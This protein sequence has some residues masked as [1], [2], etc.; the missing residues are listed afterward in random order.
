MLGW[1][2]NFACLLFILAAMPGAAVADYS[3]TSHTSLFMR[4]Y[5]HSNPP[6]G[7]VR[8]CE[9][10]PRECQARPVQNQRLDL[11][12]TLWNDL[13]Q[14]NLLVNKTVVPVS[15]QDLYGRSEYWTFPYTS[16]DCEDYVLLKRRLLIRR[17]WPLSA[18]L[19][20]VVRDERGGGHA[21]LIARTSKGDFLLDNKRDE[22]VAWYKVP[23]RYLKRQSYRDPKRWMSLVP[24]RKN[25]VL[26]LAGNLPR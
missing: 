18:L 25:A 15:D 7:F 8:F 3:G 20:T 2:I 11:T 10:N 17:G 26:S 5:G 24:K 19:I 12:P 14:V 22:V 1:R 13:E 16:G 6:M 23:Y 21:V 9:L 4:V